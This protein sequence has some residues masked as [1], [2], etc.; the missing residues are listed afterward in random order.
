MA[1]TIVIVDKGSTAS[2]N[3]AAMSANAAAASA[4]DAESSAEA[5]ET[6]KTAAELA[7]SNVDQTINAAVANATASAESS[8]SAAAESETN[9]LT[10]KTA[11]ET[12]A[13]AANLSAQATA[14]V[15][16]TTK[17][18]MDADLAHA[19]NILALVTNDSTSTNN[20]IYIKLGASGSG[21]WQKS[22]YVP[23]VVD[24]SVTSA[25]ITALAAKPIIN[26]AGSYFVFDFTAKTISVP[27]GG[28]RIGKTV[29]SFSAHTVDFSNVVSSSCTLYF[30][31]STLQFKVKYSADIAS[32]PETYV[33]AGVFEISYKYINVPAPCITAGSSVAN[34]PPYAITPWINTAGGFINFD[35]TNYILTVPAGGIRFGSKAWDFSSHTVD[36]S[37]LVPG[38]QSFTIAFNINT[39]KFE[40]YNG[41]TIPNFTGYS[42]V[43]GILWLPSK[44]ITIN[45]P[46]T[47]NG[48]KVVAGNFGIIGGLGAKIDFR[49]A[50]NTIFIPAI[51]NIA[52]KNTYLDSI[53]VTGAV[54]LTINM[55]TS[56]SE[57]LLTFDTS[58]KTFQVRTTSSIT[59]I[60]PSEILLALFSRTYKKVFMLGDFLIDGKRPYD[61]DAIADYASSDLKSI[62]NSVSQVTTYNKLCFGFITDTHGCIDHL[63][64][65]SSMSKYGQMDFVV[66]GGDSIAG[67]TTID[68]V[69]TNLSEYAKVFDGIKQ[70]VFC[71]R[72]NHD[73][74]GSQTTGDLTINEWFSRMVRPFR[75]NDI[76][77]NPSEPDGGYYY[78]DFDKFKIRAIF[79]NSASQP[80]DTVL[81]WGWSPTQLQW[82]ANTALDLSSKGGDEANWH[83]IAFG[84]HCTRSR[85]TGVTVAKYGAVI[86]QILYAYKNGTSYTDS[87][88]SV[89]VDFSSQGAMNLIA[90]VF[91]H[92]HYDTMEIPEDLGFPMISV[93]SSYPDY[94]ESPPDGN[95]SYT[96]TTG[97]NTE[98][99]WD[100]FV[101]DKTSRTINT[102]RYGAGIDRSIIY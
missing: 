73:S 6:S 67:E 99:A 53:N 57:E 50:S 69:R 27:A 96:R 71:M 22:S 16:F 94:Y 97:T 102:Y 80:Y 18:L 26:T 78:Q 12:A 38:F 76:V 9:A 46:Y 11:A 14:D 49:F 47:V 60:S 59:S 63:K 40:I 75:Q 70:P 8:A 7:E 2:I 45:A 85:Y 19:A 30:D 37:A 90:Y 79:T 61:D 48:G 56:S 54:D 87:E 15:A 3:Q 29:Y 68:T 101:V 23:P 81:R 51:T 21:S 65:I 77:V 91:G 43:V 86:E 92:T 62:N 72:G 25:K 52:V 83:V 4:I 44:Q 55:I 58:T 42:S 10:Y 34:V 88:T 74:D 95:Y 32:T 84:H 17:A 64:A 98:D 41:A 1:D 20:G 5:A 66:H 28:L 89:S 35:L 36:F 82:I 93:L 33:L 100:V 31:T 13:N 39:L 24:G